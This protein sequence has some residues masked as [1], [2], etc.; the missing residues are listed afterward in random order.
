MKKLIF[1]TIAV[2]ALSQFE[3]Q[4]QNEVKNK[5]FG[6]RAGWQI[7]ITMND[8]EQVGGNLNTFYVGVYGDRSLGGYESLFYHGGLEYNTG[9]WRR[10]DNNYRKI[11]YLN[12]PAALKVK[13]GPVRRKSWE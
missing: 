11:H 9:G 12:G 4:A 5:D 13:L 3:V 7:S 8:G 6:I 2:F 10:D 1:T